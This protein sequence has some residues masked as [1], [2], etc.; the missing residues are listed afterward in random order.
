MAATCKLI[1]DKDYTGEGQTFCSND[2]CLRDTRIFVPRI[3]YLSY[4]PDVIL[5]LHG[6]YVSSSKNGLEPATGYEI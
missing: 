5:W 6:W 1:E 2:R 3:E 4:T